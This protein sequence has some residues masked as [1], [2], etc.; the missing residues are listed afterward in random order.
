MG[1]NRISISGGFCV[2]LAL[3]LLF[4]PLRWLTAA[5]VAAVWHELCHYF[6]ICLMCRMPV[7]MRL[8]SFAAYLQLPQMGRG[9]EAVCALAGPIGG[10]CLLFFARWMPRVAICAAFQSLYNLLPIFPLDGGRAIRCVLQ[11]LFSPPVSEKIS[12]VIGSFCKI[13]IWF[14][15]LYGSFCL[16]LG[17]FPLLMALLFCIRIK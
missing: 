9:R 10:L 1:Q 3:L 11:L 14:L 16:R 8:Y 12:S 13:A 17:V 15:A 5:A 7:N 4:V 6:A 2:T